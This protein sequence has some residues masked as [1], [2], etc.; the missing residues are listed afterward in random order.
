MITKQNWKEYIIALKV[1]KEY[2]E[3][4]KEILDMYINTI[5]TII[6]TPLAICLD[7]LLLPF[8]IGF[9]IFKKIMKKRLN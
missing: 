7:I 4:N 1:F 6:I 3:F 5:I 9:I 8:E 2:G